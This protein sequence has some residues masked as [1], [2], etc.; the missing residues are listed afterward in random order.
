MKYK[1]LAK[2]LFSDSKVNYLQNDEHIKNYRVFRE[3]NVAERRR[4]LQRSLK[5]S[6]S[7]N[8]L[9]TLFHRLGP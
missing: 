7:L 5:F 9:F 2:R 6:V 8:L 1:T 3:H 4:A